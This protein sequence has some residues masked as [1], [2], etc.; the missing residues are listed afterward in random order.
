MNGMRILQCVF[1][2]SKTSL[3]ELVSQIILLDNNGMY[4]YY[5]NEHLTYIRFPSFSVPCVY[6]N[7]YDC[8]QIQHILSV[9]GKLSLHS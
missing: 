4:I 8:S 2:D 5:S 9:S 6:N 1:Y 3:V 7:Y